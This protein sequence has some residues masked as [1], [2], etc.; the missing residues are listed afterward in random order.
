MICIESK[1]ID[2]TEKFNPK[3]VV[4]A[5]CAFHDCRSFKITINSFENKNC[6]LKVFSSSKFNRKSHAFQKL[7]RNLSGSERIRVA[8]ILESKSSSYFRSTQVNQIFDNSQKAKK[9][10]SGHIQSAKSLEVLIEAKSD[11]KLSEDF[12]KIH[13]KISL[14]I[15]TN[16]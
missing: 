4:Y 5:N 12:L 6:C 10:E 11:F 7:C 14:S 3:A 2:K 8:K 16:L 13:T 15:L 9:F 1:R